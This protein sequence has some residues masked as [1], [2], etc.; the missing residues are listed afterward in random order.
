[1]AS[2]STS[3]PDAAETHRRE[4]SQDG[5]G[6]YSTNHQ[7]YTA[8]NALYQWHLRQFMTCLFEVVAA[9]EPATVLDAGCGEGF[10]IDFLKQRDAGLDLTGV[11]LSEEAVDYARTR[12]GDQATFRTGDLYDLPFPDDAFDTVLCS[13]VLE[14]LDDPER[15]ARELGRVARNYVVITVPREPYFKWLND[16]GRWLSLSPDPG[17]VNFW[18]RETFQDFIT[19]QYRAPSFAWKH[20]FQLARAKV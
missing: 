10:I 14:H 5:G 11:D 19:R 6:Y 9:T 8:D 12:F 3:A 13:E 7:K 20:V 2:P 18:T 17:H 15:A 1:M 16:L 4:F